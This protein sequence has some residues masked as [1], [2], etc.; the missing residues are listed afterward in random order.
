MNLTKNL[1]SR[2]KALRVSPDY[3]AFV[4]GD[5]DAWGNVT[6]IFDALKRGQKVI[7]YVEGKFVEAKVT[8]VDNKS[9]RAIDGPVIR[10]SNG[11]Y[12]WR[13][14]GDCWAYPITA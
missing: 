7:T 2:S 12:S 9:F 5:F 14:D 4:E 11:E 6:D 3:V 8:M 13:V 10:V 1:I